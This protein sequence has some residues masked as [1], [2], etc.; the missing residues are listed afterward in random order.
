MGDVRAECALPMQ[1][2]HER[3]PFL[4]ISQDSGGHR[5]LRMKLKIRRIIEIRENRLL[6]GQT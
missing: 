3:P 5:S 2:L 1:S 6:M 4:L